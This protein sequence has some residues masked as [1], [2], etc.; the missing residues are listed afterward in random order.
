MHISFESE[1]YNIAHNITQIRSGSCLIHSHTTYEILYML[2]GDTVFSIGGTE[3]MLEPH[4]MLLI[5]PN[6]FH[7]I[8]VLTCSPMTGIPYILI[9][10]SCPMSTAH[11][12]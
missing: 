9:Q 3:Y 7:G 1:L 12:C 11:C 4:T 10:A 6:V 8:H 2:E 5:P